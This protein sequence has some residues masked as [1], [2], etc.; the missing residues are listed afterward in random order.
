M[1]LYSHNIINIYNHFRNIAK[2]L[3]EYEYKI[4]RRTKCKEDYLRYLQYETDLLKLIKQRRDVS[5][6]VLLCLDYYINYKYGIIY[7]F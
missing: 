4:Q 6:Y 2:K 7:E 1:H 3:K 5:S